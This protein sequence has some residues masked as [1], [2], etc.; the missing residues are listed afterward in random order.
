MG[1]FCGGSCYWVYF[2]WPSAFY[3]ELVMS[4]K[5]RIRTLA[6]AMGWELANNGTMAYWK[7]PDGTFLPRDF[8]PFTSADD[9]YACLEWA[10]TNLDPDRFFHALTEVVGSYCYL[11]EYRI[12]YFA[13]A[14]L[15]VLDDG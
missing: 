8:Q 10:R 3:G 6:E 4:D 13:A 11:H 15:K 14:A 9:D 1:R 2:I 12:G 5:D 7:R